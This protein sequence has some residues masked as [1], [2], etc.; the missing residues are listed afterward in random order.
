MK[1]EGASS[2]NETIRKLIEKAEMVPESGFGMY[3]KLGRRVLLT[4][5]EHEEITRSN[6]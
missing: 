4:Q 5:K 3:K 1:A 2:L 6:H